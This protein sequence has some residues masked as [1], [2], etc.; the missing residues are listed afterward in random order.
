MSIKNISTFFCNLWRLNYV[1]EHHSSSILPAT[2]GRSKITQRKCFRTPPPMPPSTLPSCPN[3]SAVS[4]CIRRMQCQGRHRFQR[5]FLNSKAGA[6]C[7]TKSFTGQSSLGSVETAHSHMSVTTMW[8]QCLLEKSRSS[9][10]FYT[11][12]LQMNSV[13]N[14]VCS[15]ACITSLEW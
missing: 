14:S 15:V 10:A 1:H 6:Q 11:C 5:S 8:I 4:L 12:N 7:R 9:L 3:S 2:D 13:S